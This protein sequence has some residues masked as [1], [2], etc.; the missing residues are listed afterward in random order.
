MRDSSLEG[1]PL[2]PVGQSE[3]G[4][5][6]STVSHPLFIILGGDDISI[7]HLPF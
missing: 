6:S 1:A 7:D 5:Q 3:G 2:D 4:G